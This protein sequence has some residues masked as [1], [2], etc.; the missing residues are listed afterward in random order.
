[1][2]VLSLFD[3]IS[4]T[5]QALK[6]LGI[7]YHYYASEIDP[8]A[9]KITQKNFPN[10]I[11]LGDVRNISFFRTNEM[12]VPCEYAT[13]DSLV[14]DKNDNICETYLGKIDLMCGGSPCQDLSIA[15]KDRKGLDGERSGL[16]YEYVR[17]LKEVKPKFFILENVASMS[18]EAKQGITSHLYG[19]EPVLLN[20]ALVSA[21]Q[22]KRLFWVSKRVD[23]C[24]NC[25]TK[26]DAISKLN[27]YDAEE[28]RGILQKTQRER[29]REVS[30]KECTKNQDMQNMSTNIYS[31]GKTWYDKDLFS[32]VS[33]HQQEEQRQKKGF[34]KEKGVQQRIC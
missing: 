2:K 13:D 7:K 31:I 18:K 12:G 3:G 16:F 26:Q 8:Y 22:R 19:I 4:A 1:M 27:N 24:D 9:I 6:N 25:I 32:T 20:S 11:Q 28:K 33:D 29:V 15:K 21:Q 34:T 5:N 30:K 23:F 14:I 10:T 17:I